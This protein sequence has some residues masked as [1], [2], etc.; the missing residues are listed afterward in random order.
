MEH[1]RRVHSLLLL[2][3]C[4]SSCTRPTHEPTDRTPSDS[5]EIERPNIILIDIDSL[6]AELALA[7][8]AGVRVAP[9]LAGLEEQGLRFSNTWSQ[10]GWTEPAM[11]ALLTGKVPLLFRQD[12]NAAK[13][14]QRY[15]PE[16]LG[17]YGYHTAVLWEELR[18]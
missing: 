3:L 1:S 12:L 18:P 17:F 6:G 14:S 7:Q 4:L 5:P 13:S 10:G 15:L 2:A 16:I 11:Q 9:A 8:V